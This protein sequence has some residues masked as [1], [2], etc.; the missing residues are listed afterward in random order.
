MGDIFGKFEKGARTAGSVAKKVERGGEIIRDINNGLTYKQLRQI[1]DFLPPGSY[2]QEYIYPAIKTAEDIEDLKEDLKEEGKPTTFYESIN[3]AK[4]T[5]DI[6]GGLPVIGPTKTANKVIATLGKVKRTARYTE[7]IQKIVAKVKEEE[8]E[9]RN[10]PEIYSPFEPNDINFQAPP[11][12]QVQDPQLDP[13]SPKEYQVTSYEI[14]D[15]EL[16]PLS[17]NNIYAVI[18]AIPCTHRIGKT[19]EKCKTQDP[20]TYFVE[21]QPDSKNPFT[22]TQNS[23]KTQKQLTASLNNQRYAGC[24]FGPESAQKL[25][26]DYLMP[27]LLGVCPQDNNKINIGDQLYNAQVLQ[28]DWRQTT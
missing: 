27:A 26:N 5:A 24:L 18:E 20:E 3:Y 7:E 23:E 10:Q 25:I 1:T 2:K 13:S 21:L 28:G 16:T 22:S 8:E 4:N 17:G 19:I 15:V 12:A 6:I 11:I 14:G 9:L